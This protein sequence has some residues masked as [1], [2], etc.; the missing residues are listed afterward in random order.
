MIHSSTSMKQYGRLFEMGTFMNYNIRSGHLLA[1]AE[2]GP[3]VMSRGKIHFLPKKIK[4]ADK[5][6][7][8]FTKFQDKQKKRRTSMAE[9]EYAYFSGCSLEGTAKEYD[10]SLRVVMK[11]LGVDLVE[12]EDW[13]CCGST[14]A[15]TVE[16]CLCG[17]PCG[18]KPCHR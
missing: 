15:H 2:L 4:G 10:E 14:P 13:S 9:K 18:K 11:A 6:A 8:I 17:C 16:P 7:K 12:P 5:V 3:K 1:D